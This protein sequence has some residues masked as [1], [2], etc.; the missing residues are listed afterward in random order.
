VVTDPGSE[1]TYVTRFSTANLDYTLDQLNA[2]DE[3]E[4][5]W[6]PKPHPDDLRG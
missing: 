2:V 1:L 4:T 3:G 5:A 6:K